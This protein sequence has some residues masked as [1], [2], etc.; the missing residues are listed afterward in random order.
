MGPI[1]L[2][3]WKYVQQKIR[4]GFKNTGD[5]QSSYAE[6]MEKMDS[7]EKMEKMENRENG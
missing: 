7:A 3:L 1:G 2:S 5:T 4:Y 6:K